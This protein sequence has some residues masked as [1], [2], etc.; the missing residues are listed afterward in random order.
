MK[1]PIKTTIK[2]I[3]CLSS[4]LVGMLLFILCMF[5][6]LYAIFE[7]VYYL[8]YYPTFS[9]YVYFIYQ[10]EVIFKGSGYIIF[11]SIC[12]A[13]CKFCVI[14]IGDYID[15]P[16][17]YKFYQEKSEHISKDFYIMLFVFTANVFFCPFLYLK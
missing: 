17:Y 16:S 3:V 1:V 4:I 14:D 10:P 12:T 8:P 15:Y 6:G 7:F 2:I 9:Q 11:L 13:I 5:I